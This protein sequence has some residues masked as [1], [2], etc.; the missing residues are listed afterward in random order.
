MKMRYIEPLLN[1]DRKGNLILQ[2]S[3]NQSK[4]IYEQL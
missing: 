1:D 4:K 3:I 2:T